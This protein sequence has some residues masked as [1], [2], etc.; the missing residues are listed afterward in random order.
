MS[1]PL[2]L[3][4]Q[5]HLPS[6]MPPLLPYTFIPW[7][8]RFILKELSEIANDVERVNDQTL[9]ADPHLERTMT[10]C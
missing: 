2:L 3:Y 10:V 8:K 9:E 6:L 4:K 5:C 1:L 7:Q